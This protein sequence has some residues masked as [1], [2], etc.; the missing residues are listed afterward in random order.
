MKKSL[1]D[2]YLSFC[3]TQ[4]GYF[5]GKYP[6]FCVA[7]SF[8][9]FLIMG[10]GFVNYSIVRDI[11]YLFAPIDGRAKN[12]RQSINTL[13]SSEETTQDDM[14]RITFFNNLVNVIV[15]AKNNGFLMDDAPVKDL[16]QID[17]IVRNVSIFYNNKFL[18]FRDVC[19]KNER[20]KCSENSGAVLKNKLRNPDKILMRYPIER[21][22]FGVETYPIHLGGVSTNGS[23]YILNFKAFRMFYFMDFGTEEKTRIAVKWEEAVIDTLSRVK[24]RHIDVMMASSRS[25]DAGAT[26]NSKLSMPLMAISGPIMILFSM[27]SCMTLDIVSS[28]PLVGLAGLVSPLVATAAAFG[29]LLHCGMEYVDTNIAVAFLLIGIGMD[30]SFVLVA[31]WRRTNKED[32][33]KKRMSEAFSEAGVSISITS[34]TNLVCFCVGLVSP[35]KTVRIFCTYSAVSVLFDLIYQIFFFGALLALDGYR[36]QHRL[37]SFLC[38]PVKRKDI[39]NETSEIEKGKTESD[40]SDVAMKYVS[41]KLGNLLCMKI[42]KLVVIIMFCSIVAGSV[43]NM[44]NMK[45]GLEFVDAF[46]YSSYVTKFIKGHYRYFTDY[47]HPIQIVFNRSLDYSNSNVQEDVEKILQTFENAPYVGSELSICWIREYLSFIRNDE[48]NYLMK[49]FNTSDSRGFVEGLKRVFLRIKPFSPFRKDLVWNKERNQILA[50]RCFVISKDVRSGSDEKFMLEDVRRIADGSKHRVFVYNFWFIIY[51]Q[52]LNV[53]AMCVQNVGVA[54]GMVSLI[55]LILIQ[56]VRI[57][58]C[59]TLNVLC[60]LIQTVGYMNCWKVKLDLVSVMT[61]VMSAG[62]SVDFSAHV[63]YAYKCCQ[64]ES[65][66][67][68]IKASLYAAGYPVIQGCLSTILGI[69]PLAFG[70][71]YLFLLF[72]KQIL[73]VMIFAALNGLILL[74]VLLSIADSV[75]IPWKKQIIVDSSVENRPI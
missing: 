34:F 49:D 48:L 7:V 1:I 68:K 24:F 65:S 56:D 39:E 63:A 30:D 66:E 16:V 8:L 71:S 28:K 5:V 6:Q 17:A 15:V 22:D 29:L 69:V 64:E 62:F 36:E 41:E 12:E 61:L 14:L 3:F 55:L 43:Y 70:P 27:A 4:I 11:E 73:L 72:F 23:G 2:R 20:N 53:L 67:K 18:H 57:T 74:P 38:Y 40:K 44:R 19:V 37:H 21:S 10:S 51:D 54:L 46:P 31:S 59:V 42:V 33:V 60:I 47:P 50:S 75:R 52:Y 45:Q 32:S 13:F 9:V 58:V 25:F 35:Y 26:V